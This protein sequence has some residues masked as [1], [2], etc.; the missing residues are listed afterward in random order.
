MGITRIY[1]LARDG[2]LLVEIA[3]LIIEHYSL[4]IE[5]RYLYVS[6]QSLHLPRR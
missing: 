5:A 1:F 2:E 6:R 3:K 4:K